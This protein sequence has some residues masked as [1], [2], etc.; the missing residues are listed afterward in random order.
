MRDSLHQRAFSIFEQACDLPHGERTDFVSRACGADD[1]LRAEVTSLLAHDED[2]A[3]LDAA[4]LNPARDL[5]S[6]TAHEGHASAAPSDPLPERLGAYR[7][8]RKIGEGGMGE[9]FEAEQ[10]SPK[11]RVALKVIRAGRLTPMLVRRFEHE[12][13]VLGRLQHPGIA[14]IYESGMVAVNGKQQPFFAMEYIDG[15]RIT[16]YANEHRLGVRQRL[17]LIVRVCDAVQHAHQ[18]GIIH[19]DLKPA[20]I[21]VIAHDSPTGTGTFG[22]ST[23]SHTIDTIGQPKILDFG[24]ARV[25]DGD[26]QAATMQTDVGQLVGTLAYMSPEQVAGDSSKLDTRCDVYALGVVMFQ[27]LTGRL[28]LDISHQSIAE[29]ARIIRDDEPQSAGAIV[30]SLR[31]DVDT[32]IAKA[33]EKDPDQRYASAAQLAADI[34]RNLDDE[35]IVARP[36]SAVYQ[37]RKFARRNKGLVGGLVATFVVL[38]IGLLSTGYFLF[39]AT[40]QRDKAIAARDEAHAAREQ[41]DSARVRA[42]L[43]R[44]RTS[45]VAAFQAKVLQNLQANAFGKQLMKA[46]RDEVD[47]A[48]AESDDVDAEGLKKNLRRI[49][50]TNV[51]RNLLS[52]ALADRALSRIEDGFTEDPVTE[53]ELRYSVAQMYGNLGVFSAAAEQY[54]RELA[55]RREHQGSDHEETLSAMTNLGLTYREMGRIRDSKSLYQEVLDR[56]RRIH[57]DDDIT[58]L[59]SM[60]NL[61][62]LLQYKGDLAE[63]EALLRTVMEGTERIKGPEDTVTLRRRN[64]SCAVLLKQ[65]KIDE[66]LACFKELYE[67]R[68]RVNGADHK[69]TI[70]VRNNLM[71]TLFKAGR[72]EEAEPIARDVLASSVRVLGDEHPNTIMGRNNLGVLL[73]NLD[74]PQEA[75]ALFRSAYES[76]QTQLNPV[77]EVRMKSTS[78]LIDALLALE[79]PAEAT[80]LCHELIAVRRGMDPPQPGLV[81]QT[82]EQLGHAQYRQGQYAAARDAW[83]ECV[84]LRA[85]I[86]SKHWLTNR[87]R[88][89]LG[90]SLLS[91]GQFVEAEALLLDSYNAL[92][93]QHGEIPQVA[94]KGCIDNA[95]QRIVALYEV[96]GRPDDAAKWREGSVSAKE[97]HNE[98]NTAP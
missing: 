13:F 6:S 18:K 52:G 5:L 84:D 17:A 12:A 32:I 33:L 72:F 97:N 66:A 2:P 30:R 25:T 39:E 51:A 54:E 61:A 19:R 31:G 62:G 47:D 74:R 23:G 68:N 86:S 8:I 77:H 94:G 71:G 40:H 42:D 85:G 79:Q 95:R 63:A 87:A 1:A 34:R 90:E 44:D 41:A 89:E 16:T 60:G 27:L 28:P 3:D 15:E 11:R 50:S 9:V 76:S 29:V 56:R 38:I 64:T 20:N 75:E 48:F 53:A 67:T 73:L 78:N 7:I 65:Q 45:A 88:S 81:A 4:V 35:P 46:L 80:P 10:E 57:G 82:L 70:T 43:A 49:N 69:E 96:W 92:V 26:V 55:L 22:S 93:A 91:L 59:N 24:I 58:V 37:I 83:Q 36:A 21:L 14:H 98:S